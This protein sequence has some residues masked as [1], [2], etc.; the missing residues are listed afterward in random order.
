MGDLRSCWTVFGHVI[1]GR[2]GGLF[3]FSGEG[4]IRII[5]V[6]ASSSIRAM[7]RNMERRRDWIIDDH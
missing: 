5:L 4:F 6:S 7:C 3:Q 2:P 1:R